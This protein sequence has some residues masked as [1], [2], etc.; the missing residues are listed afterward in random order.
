MIIVS[1]LAAAVFIFLAAASLYVSSPHQ[2]VG[3][4]YGSPAVLRLASVAAL[5]ISLVLLMQFFSAPSAVFVMLTAF[6]L[7]CSI[8]PI[9][10]AYWRRSAGSD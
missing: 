3:W 8:V 7:L 5:V 2:K 10:I 6:M 1:L 9:G 4:R